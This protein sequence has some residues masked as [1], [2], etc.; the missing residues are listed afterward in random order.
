MIN[1]KLKLFLIIIV[2]S[3]L[4]CLYLIYSINPWKATTLEWVACPSPPLGHGNFPEIPKVY[5]GP[6]EYSVPGEK[7]DFTPQNKN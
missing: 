5:R 2:V 1:K 6:Y 7:D 4:V 3:I